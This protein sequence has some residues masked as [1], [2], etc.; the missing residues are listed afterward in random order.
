MP[1]CT[2]T[3]IC[4]V[5]AL[6][7]LLQRRFEVDCTH[8]SKGPPQEWVHVSSHPLRTPTRR[9]E[10]DWTRYSTQSWLETG[11]LA[12]IHIPSRTNH[13]ARSVRDQERDD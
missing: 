3:R 2:P 5:Y 6:L 9:C 1:D 13:K 7:H 10:V 8:P 12:A 11:H 4:R